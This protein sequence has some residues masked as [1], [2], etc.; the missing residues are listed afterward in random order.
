MTAAKVSMRSRESKC[1]CL[2]DLHLLHASMQVLGDAWEGRYLLLCGRKDFEQL[3]KTAL[4]FCTLWRCKVC[5]VGP[6]P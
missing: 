5:K 3:W 4:L 1:S 6:C 2:H